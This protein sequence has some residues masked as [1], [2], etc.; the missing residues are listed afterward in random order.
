M[1]PDTETKT[2][3]NFVAYRNH[4]YYSARSF[5]KQVELE[6]EGWLRKE[7]LSISQ[8]IILDLLMNSDELTVSEISEIGAM[9][10]ST[11]LNFCKRLIIDGY[12]TSKKNPLI[13]ELHI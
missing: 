3:N 1:D 13:G 11:A 6:W 4:I 2:L 7:N 12:V 9:H 5:W 8:Y 10:I